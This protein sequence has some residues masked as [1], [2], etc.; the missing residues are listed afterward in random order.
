[1]KHVFVMVWYKLWSELVLSHSPFKM[2]IAK[3]TTITCQ[4]EEKIHMYS[5]C[6][7]YP[8]NFSIYEQCSNIWILLSIMKAI[9]THDNMQESMDCMSSCYFQIR[10]LC[11]C[12]AI[13]IFQNT[14]NRHTR[15]G[16]WGWGMSCL[17]FK[18]RAFIHWAVRR[19]TTKSPEIS[20]PWDW[21]YKGHITLHFD[22]HLGSTAANVLV[23]IQC[24]WRSQ[25]LNLMA[26]SLRCLTT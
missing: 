2:Y 8:V 13:T 4:K 23:K 22:M 24:D 9:D 25:N 7:W 10:T 15:A 12:N 16:P 20:E 19:L 6:K 26:L 3:D 14:Y 21:C 1:M 5:I 11:C 17:L 18:V